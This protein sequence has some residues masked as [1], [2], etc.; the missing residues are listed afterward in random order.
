M[1]LAQRELID[2]TVGDYAREAMRLHYLDWVRVLAVLGVF[3]YHT[4]RPFMLQEWL[5]NARQKSPVITFIFLVFLGSIGMPLFFLVSG[6]GSYFALRRRTGRQYVW[7]RVRRLL[8]PFVAGCLLLSPIQFY[9]EWLHKGQYQGSFWPFLSLLVADRFKTARQHLGPTIFET[10]GSHLWFLGFLLSFSILALPLFKWLGSG[11]G[12]RQLDRLGALGEK[13]GGLFLF[14]VPVALARLLLQ[15]RFPD[16]TDWADFAYMLVFF[17]CGYLL[18]AD[19]RLASAIQREARTALAVGLLCTAVMLMLLAFASGRE[20]VGSPDKAG[21]YIG[22]SL[23]TVNGWSWTLVVLWLAMTYLDHP[24]KWLTYGQD[25][26]VPFYVFHQ[27]VIVA[28][29]F[30]IIDCSASLAAALAMVVTSSFAGTL[31]VVELGLR[32]LRFTRALFGMKLRKADQCGPKH[33][34]DEQ[35]ANVGPAA[36]REATK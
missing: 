29:A 14:V 18:F 34:R 23:A 30:Y 21:F 36:A 22:W 5:I 1:A 2:V 4:C 13:R 8:I 31:L 6:A 3:F 35:L 33:G 26:I 11:S 12:R 24:N 9:L 10:L 32:R 17:I 16:Y 19:R 27:P 20:W 7:Q 28:V 25:I 15:P